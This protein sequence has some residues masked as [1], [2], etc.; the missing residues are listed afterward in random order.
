M[1][2]RGALNYGEIANVFKY[3]ESIAGN[4]VLSIANGEKAVHLTFRAGFLVLVESNSHSRHMSD[5]LRERGLLG[6]ETL[7][8]ALAAQRA[9]GGRRKL[10]A[11]L[12]EDFGISHE[13]IEKALAEHFRAILMDVFAWTEGRFVFERSE[14]GGE[15][16]E[17]FNLELMEFLESV[18]D[19]LKK[20]AV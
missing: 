7:M 10:G 15:E 19:E 17:R 1:P 16:K 3:V 5:V 2:L 11:I 6:A 14:E 20:K 12:C 4:G 8:R 18:T 13:S 9:E